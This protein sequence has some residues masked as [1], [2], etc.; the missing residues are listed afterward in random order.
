M[1]SAICHQIVT[2]IQPTSDGSTGRH[3]HHT[4]ELAFSC[5]MMTHHHTFSMDPPMNFRRSS[6]WYTGKRPKP[7]FH[8]SV[9]CHSLASIPTFATFQLSLCIRLTIWS[10]I[11]LSPA[12]LVDFRVCSV[13]C[14]LLS[15]VFQMLDCCCHCRL[16]TAHS[17]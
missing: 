5:R 9:E 3:P 16:L 12:T 6:N 8:L 14:L 10:T 4:I 7:R 11:F 13:S 15:R 1:I 2:G 17:S